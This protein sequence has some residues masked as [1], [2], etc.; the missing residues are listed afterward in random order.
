MSKYYD[1]SICSYD[2]EFDSHYLQKHDETGAKGVELN[3]VGAC[4]PDEDTAE[5]GAAV[6]A[7]PEAD[8]AAEGTNKPEGGGAAVSPES[9]NVPVSSARLS[10]N[11][12]AKEE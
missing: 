12:D 1:S 10:S 2:S 8:D 4:A 9:D 11:V 6:G 5:L 7:D 3:N